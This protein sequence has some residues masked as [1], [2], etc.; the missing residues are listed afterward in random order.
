MAKKKRGLGRGL[1]DLLAQHDTDLPFLDAYGA[2][3]SGEG[4]DGEQGSILPPGTGRDPPEQ[5]L[6]VIIRLLRA[7]GMT[8]TTDDG[9]VI[10]GCLAAKITEDGVVLEVQTG[11]NICLPLVASDLGEPG[12]DAGKLAKDRKTAQVTIVQWGSPARRLLTRLCEHWS[13]N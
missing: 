11:G 9:A 8:L 12:L 6:S 3:Q 1:D 4:E 5:V 2:G 7:E 13:T 10:E